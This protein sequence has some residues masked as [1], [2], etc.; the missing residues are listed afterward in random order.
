[1]KKVKQSEIIKALQIKPFDV[2]N[3]RQLTS[4]Q[5]NI[6]FLDGHSVVFNLSRPVSIVK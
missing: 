2:A 3:F 5:I 4:R 1:M 6:V